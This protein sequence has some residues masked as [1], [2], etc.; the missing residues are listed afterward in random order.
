MSKSE[1]QSDMRVLKT[2]TCKTLSGKSTLTYQIGCDTDSIIHLRIAGNDGGGF[3]S[4]EW[5]ALDDVLR[6]LKDRPRESPVL[7]HLLTPL[8]K[9]KS[10]NTSAFLL[11]TLSHLKLLRPLPMKKRHHE[12]LDP[13]PFLDQ[14]EKLISSAA[15]GKTVKRTARKAPVKKAVVKKASTKKAAIKKKALSRKKTSRTV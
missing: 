15:A 9:G 8:L 5:L 4:D 2:A 12:L 1:E 11:A 10:V 14:V 13:K 6:V 7:A 3:F